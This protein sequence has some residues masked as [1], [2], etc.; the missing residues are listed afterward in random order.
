MNSL[1]VD[2]RAVTVG[3]ARQTEFA[4][5]D[6]T[7]SDVDCVVSI[8]HADLETLA[9]GTLN[10]D[11]LDITGNRQTLS[12]WLDLHDTFDLWFNVATPWYRRM[13]NLS[14]PF[15]TRKK[16]AQLPKRSKAD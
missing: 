8:K 12:Q 11:D 10:Q 16:H 14:G 6:D 5:I 2:G 7:T 3:V 13:A 9:N 1:S 15:K 4:R